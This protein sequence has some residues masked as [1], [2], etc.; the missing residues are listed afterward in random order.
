MCVYISGYSVRCIFSDY[1]QKNKRLPNLPDFFSKLQFIL[2]LSQ[3]V[4]HK[5][6]TESRALCICEDE[7][8]LIIILK[9]PKG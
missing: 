6:P 9:F 3:R 7:Q 4:E 2:H 1:A 5:V 8:Q